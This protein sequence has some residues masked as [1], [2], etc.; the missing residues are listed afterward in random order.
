MAMMSMG[1]V[2]IA[3]AVIIVIV[4]GLVLALKGR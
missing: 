1:L 3:G 2:G 4:I